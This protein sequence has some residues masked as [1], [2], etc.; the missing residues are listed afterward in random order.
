[1]PLLFERNG[2]VQQC[3]TFKRAVDPNFATERLDSVEETDQSRPF[4]DVR[5]ADSIVLHAHTEIRIFGGK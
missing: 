5:S 1:M 2:R 4:T 3:S